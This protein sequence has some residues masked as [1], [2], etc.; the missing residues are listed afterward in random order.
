MIFKN[1]LGI[2]ATLTKFLVPAQTVSDETDYTGIVGAA[3]G[4]WVLGSTLKG[5]KCIL[6]LTTGAA[7]NVT[8]ITLGLAQ[9]DAATGA[10]PAF[11][12]GKSVEYTAD[13]ASSVKTLEVTFAGL[14]ATKYYCPA[15]A[16]KGNGAG[17]V[18][19]AV[20]ALFPDPGYVA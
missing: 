8:G 1:D 2:Y 18:V 12:S 3:S 16:A 7:S 19:A 13:L 14:D 17:T 4:N 9:A 15:V 20:A 10:S 6:V 11:V 5:Q